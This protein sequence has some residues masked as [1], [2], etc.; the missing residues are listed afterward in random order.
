MARH[1]RVAGPPKQT[2]LFDLDA[3]IDPTP[4]F[5]GRAEKAVMEAPVPA[6]APPLEPGFQR[7]AQVTDADV[8]D[9]LRALE[10]VASG[11]PQGRD[12]E[13]LR[14]PREP[15]DEVAVEVA[16]N[17]LAA[18]ARARVVA[19]A[20]E[21]RMGGTP[22]AVG[23]WGVLS[24]NGKWRVSPMSACACGLGALLVVEKAKVPPGAAPSPSHAAALHLG[25]VDDCVQAFALGFDD[26][27]KR[28]ATLYLGDP[29]LDAWLVQGAI[30]AKELGL[31]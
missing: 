6:F 31:R 25:V 18:R 12:V 23:A 5:D 27:G 15:G 29:K 11:A 13:L 22:I 19:A 28:G 30:A 17:D 2:S 16:E 1:K 14:R 7:P 4:L 10:G 9:E 21:L 8:E 24:S 20:K 3:A 26:F